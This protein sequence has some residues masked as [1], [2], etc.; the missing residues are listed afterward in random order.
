MTSARSRDFGLFPIPRRCRLGP[1]REGQEPPS[2]WSLGLNLLLAAT[3][4]FTIAN[5][6]YIQPIIIQLSERYAVPSER[7]TRVASLIQA[8][9]LV[10][11]VLITPLGDLVARRPL[12]LLLVSITACLSLGQATVTNFVGF[13]AT[14]F[15]VGVF[16]VTPQI[17]NP[18]TADLAPPE[19]RSAAV[20]ITVSGL[21]CGW[22]LG[23]VLSGTIAHF[24]NSPD[25]IYFFAAASQ[26]GLL[27]MLYAFLPDFPRKAT[28]LGYFG[29]MKSMI[30][31]LYTYPVL[32]QA[33][34]VGFAMTTILTSWWT[35]LVFLL[36]TNPFNL[37]TFE[38]G[39]FG[40][41][42][43]V[44]I[45]SVPWA[46]KL[47]DRLNPW[48][49]CLLAATGQTVIAAVCVGCAG[50]NLAPVI[51]ACIFVD[52]FH[53][54]NTIGQQARI[55]SIDP[56]SRGRLN[57]CYMAFVF[58]GQATG[59]AVG[60]KLFLEYGW[61]APYALHVALGGIALGL[62]GVRGPS[63]NGWVGWGG[64]YSLSKE[65]GVEDHDLDP[66]DEEKRTAGGRATGEETIHSG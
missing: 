6:Y 55:Y 41:T 33:C 29:I 56:L 24:T 43:I 50:L 38:I 34:L 59:S 8:G 40:L 46:G 28:G 19:K 61:R 64:S 2:Q 5:L 10:G 51:I 35:T 14:S 54:V 9:Y 58:A 17:V 3:S 44:A 36:S 27:A 65:K 16:T 62:L 18:L 7:T 37:N 60:P 52:I 22:T 39:L 26:F 25:N 45:F 1:P 42:G 63:A 12:L 30:I 15:L 20:S 31:M 32:V 11:L 53:Q 48:L 13:E 66:D 23:R 47:T 4:S 49:V 57:S 21:L